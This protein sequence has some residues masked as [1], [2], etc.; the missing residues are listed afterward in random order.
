MLQLIIKKID[1]QD[2]N[3]KLLSEKVALKK[4]MMDRTLKIATWNANGLIQH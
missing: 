1:K 2:L 3:I 4:T